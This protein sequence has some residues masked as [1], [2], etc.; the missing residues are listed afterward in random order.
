MIIEKFPSEM[1]LIYKRGELKFMK[2][3]NNVIKQ[4]IYII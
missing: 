3:I 1:S 2:N 4:C